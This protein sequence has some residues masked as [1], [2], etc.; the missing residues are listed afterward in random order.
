MNQALVK[1]AGMKVKAE[2]IPVG[3]RLGFSNFTGKA[4]KCGVKG[5]YLYL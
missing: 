5:L 3:M 4:W 1:K 2:D